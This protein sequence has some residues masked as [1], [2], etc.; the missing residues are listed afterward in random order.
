[1]FKTERR[2]EPDRSAACTHE[3]QMPGRSAVYARSL[4]MKDGCWTRL[5]TGRKRED[6][7][8]PCMH[9][10]RTHAALYAH[11]RTGHA[12]TYKQA[13]RPWPCIYM[14]K[15]KSIDFHLFV[16]MWPTLTVLSSCASRSLTPRLF[17]GATHA[18]SRYTYDGCV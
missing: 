2:R 3:D 13:R 4:D 12:S 8:P 9:G 5:R 1:M 11:A 7:T 6:L 14:Q 18:A 15:L 17:S 16:A 10:A